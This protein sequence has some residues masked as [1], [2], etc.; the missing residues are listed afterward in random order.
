MPAPTTTV[1]SGLVMCAPPQAQTLNSGIRL[2][3]SSASMVSRLAP[4][5]W[6]GTKTVSGRIVV[7][8]RAGALSSPRRVVTSTGSPSCAPMRSASIGCS[9]TNG[10]SSGSSRTRRVWA[11][12][13]YWPST[14]PVVRC[15][16]KSASTGSA[17]PRCS[18]ATNRARPSGWANRS[19]N[20]R[21]VPG[22]PASGQGQKTPCSA[23]IRS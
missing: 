7:T 13:W 23:R 1:L 5:Q 6:N 2:A 16:G 11:P 4:T 17:G 20:S 22:C 8:T 21:G 19:A 14:R 15:S 3:G 10:P 12:D 9:S 18:T